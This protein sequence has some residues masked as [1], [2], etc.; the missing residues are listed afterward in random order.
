VAD[1]STRS[2]VE[3][4]VRAFYAKA[5]TDPMIGFLFTDVAKLDLESHVP[6]ITDF[7][8]TMLLGEKSYGGGAFAPHVSLH[9]KAGLRAPHFER[10]LWLWR[11]TVDELYGG[12]IAEE[13]KAHANRVAAAFYRRLA[14][15]DAG[16]PVDP[17]QSDPLAVVQYGGGD[18]GSRAQP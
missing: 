15:L 17:T 9:R 8:A 10:W 2:D 14:G 5:M 13:A 16:E 6:V 3:D 7:W 18:G 1:I 4:L 11:G 12:P